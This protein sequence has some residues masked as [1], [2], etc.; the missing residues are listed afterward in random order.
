MIMCMI[1]APCDFCV[2]GVKPTIDGHVPSHEEYIEYYLEKVADGMPKYNVLRIQQDQNNRFQLECLK[3]FLPTSEYSES[4]NSDGLK[5]LVDNFIKFAKVPGYSLFV[6]EKGRFNFTQFVVSGSIPRICRIPKI[7]EILFLETTITYCPTEPEMEE[8]VREGV[9]MVMEKAQHI[10]GLTPEGLRVQRLIQEYQLSPWYLQAIIALVVGDYSIF[11][12]Q[13]EG[14]T[15]L[16]SICG[17]VH[18]PQQ[19]LVFDWLGK[20]HEEDLRAASYRWSMQANLDG[21]VLLKAALHGRVHDAEIFSHRC[22]AA[23]GE[24][25]RRHTRRRGQEIKKPINKKKKKT[26]HCLLCHNGTHSLLG[27]FI[28]EDVYSKLRTHD[29]HVHKDQARRG[30]CA[31]AKSLAKT[32]D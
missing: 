19:C 18:S 8:W 25:D 14:T 16:C 9:N 4:D 3:K 31:A 20:V 7:S 28:H 26:D 2:N 13:P 10:P 11:K 24:D 23:L 12:D 21:E 5:Q 32:V 29:I 22:A 6:G 30:A 27:C 15:N 1:T 17:L